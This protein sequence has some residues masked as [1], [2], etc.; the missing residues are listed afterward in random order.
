MFDSDAYF[1]PAVD[2]LCIKF[3]DFEEIYQ[4]GGKL[5]LENVTHLVLD[6]V[7]F[8]FGHDYVGEEHHRTMARQ[9]KLYT[10]ISIHCPALKKLNLV[11]GG[12]WI[13]DRPDGL[14]GAEHFKLIDVTEGASDFSWNTERYRQ[15]RW[16][17]FTERGAAR[18]SADLANMIA[19]DN[20]NLAWLRRELNH[21]TRKMLRDFDRFLNAKEGSQ[22]EGDSWA[23]PSKKTLRYWQNLRPVPSILVGCWNHNKASPCSCS[24]DTP[25]VYYNRFRQYLAIHKD[26]TPLNMYKGLA[27]IFEGAPW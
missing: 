2:A 23:M 8:G 4:L 22:K 11:Q 25:E 5:S 14:D 20:R 7:F 21:T 6:N 19:E 1:R 13:G 16:S 17:R 10:L 12:R 15:W 27:Q 9:V 26:G 3:Q 24:S 18:G